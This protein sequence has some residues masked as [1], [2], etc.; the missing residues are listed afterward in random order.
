MPDLNGRRIAFLATD[1][2]EQ[3]ELIEPWQAIEKAGGRPELLSITSGAITG[4]ITGA[5]RGFNHLNPGAAFPVDREVGGAQVADYDA[6]VLPGWGGQ[7]RRAATAPGGG[8]LRP[9]VQ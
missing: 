2:V 5:I 4:A 9:R 6:L 7:P 1:G 3:V 8:G